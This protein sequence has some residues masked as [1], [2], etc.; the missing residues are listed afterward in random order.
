MPFS[1]K[2]ITWNQCLTVLKVCLENDLEMMQERI[3]KLVNVHIQVLLF[4][5][6]GALELVS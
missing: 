1:K 3:F 6:K 5:I 2:L 4:L